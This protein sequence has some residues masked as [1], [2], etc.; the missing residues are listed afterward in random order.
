MWNKPYFEALRDTSD[1]YSLFVP[2]GLVGE[3][4]REGYQEVPGSPWEALWPLPR[5]SYPLKPS[6][7]VS[8]QVGKLGALGWT[9][10]SGSWVVSIAV[11]V[12]LRLHFPVLPSARVLPLHCS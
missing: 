2:A 12:R 8:G 3:G 11:Q 1:C 4:R 6:P 5:A 10:A 7:R 9:P